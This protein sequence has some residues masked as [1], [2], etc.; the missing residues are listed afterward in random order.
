MFLG[1]YCLSTT[2][3]DFTTP[4]YF[5]YITTTRPFGLGVRS[6]LILLRP[7]GLE[8]VR[9]G[10]TSL[11]TSSEFLSFPLFSGTPKT[12]FLLPPPLL[13]VIKQKVLRTDVTTQDVY[14]GNKKLLG[15]KFYSIRSY[16]KTSNVGKLQ[17]GSIRVFLLLR[18]DCMVNYIKRRDIFRRR[19]KCVECTLPGIL[20]VTY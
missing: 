5:Y 3:Y 13:T 7:F 2:T 16:S 1:L 8:N 9:L 17:T 10:K 15:E 12:L 19:K 18:I 4:L 11:F 6:I 14:R 20:G